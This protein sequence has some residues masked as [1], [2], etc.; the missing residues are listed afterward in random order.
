MLELPF[1]SQ[2]PSSRLPVVG[3]MPEISR[4]IASASI[5]C[6][7]QLGGSSLTGGRGAPRGEHRG[8]RRVNVVKLPDCMVPNALPAGFEATTTRPGRSRR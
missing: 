8:S 1:K 2:K 4:P 5:D 6:Q 3:Q 7:E